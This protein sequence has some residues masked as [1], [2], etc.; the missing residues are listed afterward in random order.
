MFLAE[1]H[2]ANYLDKEYGGGNNFFNTLEEAIK[3][4]A[5]ILKGDLENCVF[6]E[7]SETV[8]RE[9]LESDLFEEFFNKE[10]GNWEIEQEYT[11]TPSK[12][13]IVEI[14]L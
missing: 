12:V 6:K 9:K 8:D 10:T 2:Y 4:S 14:K 3:Y 13:E 7:E 1:Y 5:S 11:E